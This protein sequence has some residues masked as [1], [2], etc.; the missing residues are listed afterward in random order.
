MSSELGIKLPATDGMHSGKGIKS[1]SLEESKP[2]LRL[3][4]LSW[5]EYPHAV[6]SYDEPVP[7]PLTGATLKQILNMQLDQ[8]TTLRINKL[9]HSSPGV[10]KPSLVKRKCLPVNTSP[11]RVAK[12]SSPSSSVVEEST[13]SLHSPVANQGSARRRTVTFSPNIMVFKY[14]PPSN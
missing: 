5:L 13:I 8:P 11:P 10:K 2:K 14:R 9:H 12:A 3:G 4:P 1:Q 6:S 7:D